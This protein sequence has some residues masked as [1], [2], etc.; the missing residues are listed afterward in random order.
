MVD[1]APRFKFTYG[2]VVASAV[3]TISAIAL[4]V[5]TLLLFVAVKGVT[6]ETI[7]FTSIFGMLALLLLAAAYASVSA[8]D[9]DINRRP[10]V[11]QPIW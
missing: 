9:E 7:M 4:F 10:E 3:L 2:R 8:Q 11:L 5:G 6:A 1:E